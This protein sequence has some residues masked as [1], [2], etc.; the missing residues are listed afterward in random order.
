MSHVSRIRRPVALALSLAITLSFSGCGVYDTFHQAN[1]VANEAKGQYDKKVESRAVVKVHDGAWLLGDKIQASSPQPAIFDRQVVFRNA[2]PLSLSDIATWIAS[3]VGVPASVDASVDGTSASA[4]SSASEASG[5]KG[6][7]SLTMPLPSLPGLMS[8][9]NAGNSAA[10]VLPQDQ[11]RAAINYEGKLGGLLDVVDARYHVWSRYRD[12]RITFFRTETRTFSIP[13]IADSGSMKGT[14]ST[15]GSS[16]GGS[17]S[18]GSSSDSASGDSQNVAMNVDLE[19]WKNIEKTVS[20]VAGAGST[21]VAD[22]GLGMLTVTGTPPQCDRVADWVKSMT[23]MFGK[24]VAIDVHLYQIK[25]T[26][27]D[28]YG[29]KLTLAFASSGGH[30]DVSVSSAGIPS[31]SSSSSAMS[32]GA[33]IVGGTLSGSSATIQALSTL[34][35]VSELVSRSGITQNGKALAL[36]AATEEGYVQSTTTTSTTSVGSSTSIQTGTLV[37]GFTS[38]FLPKVVDGRILIDFDMTLSNLD[39][40]ATYTSGSSSNESSVELPTM[41]MTRLQQSVSL[42]PGETLVLT[43]MKQQKATTTNNGEGSAYLPIF[44]GGVDAQRD[45][46]VIAVVITAR[47]L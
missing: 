9:A 41:E 44:G 12:G 40:L 2:D 47:L 11:P 26:S 33:S 3:N 43:G 5:A 25:E 13:I 37:P 10:A 35:K 34:G 28:N 14:I 6:G 8:A 30:T 32:F 39:S 17:S 15:K 16:Y 18:S 4:A 38:S 20:A 29:D 21:V 23:A 45:N 36:Q 7:K 31:V 24:Q 22:S 27:E 46:V 19:P 1:E 42:K